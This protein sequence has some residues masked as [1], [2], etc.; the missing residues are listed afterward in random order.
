MGHSS[1]ANFFSS[2]ARSAVAL[3]I[4]VDI[5]GQS[6]DFWGNG[7]YSA[8][9]SVRL[10]RAGLVAAF[11]E[12]PL[13]RSVSAMLETRAASSP[14]VSCACFGPRVSGAWALFCTPAI[15]IAAIG[16]L[17]RARAPCDRA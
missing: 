3:S 16:G 6:P 9:T 13:Q 17:A 5:A 4:V 11:F 2:V 10:G 14:A 12:T 8:L 15:P 1:L 7:V